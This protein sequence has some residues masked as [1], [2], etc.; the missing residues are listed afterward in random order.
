MRENEENVLRVDVRNKT[1]F[2]RS[3]QIA[4]C[5]EARDG[6]AVKFLERN[7]TFHLGVLALVLREYGNKKSGF[8]P[9]KRW[10]P[11]ISLLSK[12]AFP[13]GHA[14]SRPY[15]AIKS[16]WARIVDLG[17]S[18]F[19]L[20]VGGRQIGIHRIPSGITD[21]FNSLVKVQGTPDRASFEI[22]VNVHLCGVPLRIETP[23]IGVFLGQLR[24]A[25]HARSGTASRPGKAE[26]KDEFNARAYRTRLKSELARQV[27]HYSKGLLA[28]GSITNTRFRKVRDDATGTTL[29]DKDAGGIVDTV[30]LLKTVTDQVVIISGV[31]GAGKSTA[32]RHLAWRACSTT[33]C[34]PL[35]ARCSLDWADSISVMLAAYGNSRG[36]SEAIVSEMFRYNCIV[37]LDGFDDLNRSEQIEF[38]RE[39]NDSVYRLRIARVYISTRDSDLPDIPGAV[40]FQALEPENG[41]A[42]LRAF[43]IRPA[44]AQRTVRQLRDSGANALLSTPMSLWF[45]AL[46]LKRDASGDIPTSLGQLMT[47]VV[48]TYFIAEMLNK[49]R[50]AALKLSKRDARDIIQGLGRLAFNMID[51]D[52]TL[53]ETECKEALAEHYRGR[54]Y[55]KE[56]A[57]NLYDS[58]IHEGFLYRE[59]D[60]GVRFWHRIFMDYFAACHM[61]LYWGDKRERCCAEDLLERYKWDDSLCM[62]CGIAPSRVQEECVKLATERYDI[63]LGVRLLS[64][65]SSASRSDTLI[66]YILGLLEPLRSDG[67]ENAVLYAHL[68]ARM[69]SPRAAERL[70]PLVDS[71]IES[72]RTAVG[73][74]KQRVVNAEAIMKQIDSLAA[75]CVDESA[76]QQRQTELNTIASKVRSGPGYLPQSFTGDAS[77]VMAAQYEPRVHKNRSFG[78]PDIDERHYYW[79]TDDVNGEAARRLIGQLLLKWR[80][81]GR[82][83]W[84][85]PSVRDYWRDKSKTSP[86]AKGTEGDERSYNEE[87]DSYGEYAADLLDSQK[88]STWLGFMILRL[89]LMHPML[90]GVET[91]QREALRDML[92]CARIEGTRM[93]NEWMRTWTLVMRRESGRRFAGLIP[94]VLC[95]AA[96]H[97]ADIWGEE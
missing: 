29:Q 76:L 82:S 97:F 20:Q 92:R 85:Y 81:R 62:L 43:G 50:I 55:P 87:L 70:L 68:L 59:R 69:N 40:R 89:A 61:S 79:N 56:L 3:S 74:R 44:L 12:G 35:Y 9:V 2:L 36:D 45:V 67:A 24:A 75:G 26:R 73:L 58:A 6:I 10:A 72:I 80:D 51:A 11:E 41:E 23:D 16:R 13:G 22:M 65:S 90:S 54:L 78:G 86:F 66:D 33:T 64:S 49:A 93:G 83:L 5:K 34:L 88:V 1:L 48:E 21:L 39:F 84:N 57:R 30:D 14:I 52:R 8:I 31:S 42:C 15:D 7:A 37:F 77:D 27:A 25:S 17:S 94:P 53:S 32:L 46:V 91:I 28:I 4:S 60:G 95:D 19:E 18:R 71:A 38:Q 47:Q 63:D 96:V